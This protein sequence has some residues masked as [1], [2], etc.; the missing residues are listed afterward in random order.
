MAIKLLIK[1]IILCSTF[2]VIVSYRILASVVSDSDGSAFVTKAEFETLKNDFDEQINKYNASIDNKIDGAIASYLDGIDINNKY[3]LENKYKLINPTW[4]KNKRFNKSKKGNKYVKYMSITFATM[5]KTNGNL[6]NSGRVM[7]LSEW[8]CSSWGVVTPLTVN[9]SDQEYLYK[10]NKKTI[11]NLGQQYVL[12]SLIEP[13]YTVSVTGGS[14]GNRGAVGTEYGRYILGETCQFTKGGDTK[15]GSY[16]KDYQIYA[17]VSGAQVATGTK[18]SVAVSWSYSDKVSTD[19][20]L[21]C[22]AGGK[23][24]SDTMYLLDQAKAS[25][26]GEQIAIASS[27]MGL[28]RQARDVSGWSIEKRTDGTQSTYPLSLNAAVYRHNYNTIASTDLMHEGI[29]QVMSD[30]VYYYYNGCPLFTT[31]S[32]DGTVKFK[33]KFTNTAG[34]QTKWALKASEFSNED[35]PQNCDNIENCSETSFLTNSGS[36]IEVSFDVKKDTTYWIK[37]EPVSGYTTLEIVGDITQVGGG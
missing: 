26:L 24:N 34:A 18:E 30:K 33:L 20:T 11:G 13:T 2:I 6:V 19:A 32:E 37:A 22:L 15:F 23:L 7:F 17:Y 3:K 35:N 14:A 8:T 25:E 4:M 29:T 28:S 10:V 27:N 1:R 36:T 5:N 21:L 12:D 31:A 9:N 16:Y